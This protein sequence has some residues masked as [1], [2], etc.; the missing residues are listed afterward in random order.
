MSNNQRV[1]IDDLIV[2]REYYVIDKWMLDNTRRRHIIYFQGAYVRQ[3]PWYHHS[4]RAEFSTGNSI[5]TVNS[6]NEFYL[7]HPSMNPKLR[8]A[9]SRRAAL[10]LNPK[11]SL[12]QMQEIQYNPMAVLQHPEEYFSQ[13]TID[14]FLLS[15]SV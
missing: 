11:L 3:Y 2:G 8:G 15:K 12:D 9:I 5:K 13:D 7:I 1:Y 14:R 4:D 6:H 10:I